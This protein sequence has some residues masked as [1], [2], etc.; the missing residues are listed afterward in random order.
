MKYVQFCYD[1]CCAIEELHFVT[2]KT[3][4]RGY[5][6][7][8]NDKNFVLDDFYPICDLINFFRREI[9]VDFSRSNFDELIRYWTSMGS[10]S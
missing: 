5:M 6:V 2:D 4:K 7:G 9:V 1:F 10:E 8:S 3:K